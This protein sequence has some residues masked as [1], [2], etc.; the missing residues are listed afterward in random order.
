MLCPS[1]CS[2]CATTLLVV[3]FATSAYVGTCRLINV[4][5]SKRCLRKIV[6]TMVYRL[7]PMRFEVLCDKIARM[8]T[9]HL[10]SCRKNRSVV[11]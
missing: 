2:R 3:H 8:R 10:S 5:S 7:T 6:L 1:Q 4:I 11:R 9:E